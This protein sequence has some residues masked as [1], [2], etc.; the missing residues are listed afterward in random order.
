MR[1]GE[2]KRDSMDVDFKRSTYY[3]IKLLCGRI[4]CLLTWATDGCCEAVSGI[5]DALL[6]A[7][8]HRPA[9]RGVDHTHGDELLAK[10][11]RQ[12]HAAALPACVN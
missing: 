5:L 10:Q 3:F 9:R 12:K 11:I 4:R 2:R 6:E 1:G 7:V 8:F